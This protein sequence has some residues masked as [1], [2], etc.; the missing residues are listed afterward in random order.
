MRSTKP[1]MTKCFLFALFV[2]LLAFAQPYGGSYPYHGGGGPYGTN[3]GGVAPPALNTN[4]VTIKFGFE[5]AS[6]GLLDTAT[7]GNYLNANDHYF[8]F[9][10]V[11]ALNNPF[12]RV[13]V[14]NKPVG[15]PSFPYAV[16][17]LDPTLLTVSLG[18]DSKWLEFLLETNTGLDGI[19]FQFDSGSG[20]GAIKTVVASGWFESFGTNNSP[21][22]LI[23][24]DLW[25]F[26]DTSGN[27]GIVQYN[28]TSD[29]SGNTTTS[30]KCHSVSGAGP[31][32]VLQPGQFYLIACLIDNV[33][34]NIYVKVA[35]SNLHVVGESVVTQ[36]CV[37][38][39]KMQYQ[40]GYIGNAKGWT[41]HGPV[42]MIFNGSTNAYT[43]IFN[44]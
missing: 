26:S 35:D 39:F 43:T 9:Q 42:W 1:N 19:L 40:V 6:V 15:A 32:I 25:A 33:A 44:K 37:N 10:N 2:P 4:N 18:N 20:S 12:N 24:Q 36:N 17:I 16:N 34:G 28:L 13:F 21:S 38:L 27:Y 7:V 23:A 11:N 29:G 41:L 3:S 14:V 5:G 8:K 22:E 31:D 30:I